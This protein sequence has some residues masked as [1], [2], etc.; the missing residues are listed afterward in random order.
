MF[1]YVQSKKEIQHCKGWEEMRDKDMLKL[2]HG[3]ECKWCK[4]EQFSVLNWTTFSHYDVI[5]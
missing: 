4:K 3:R 1:K 5:R 2:W